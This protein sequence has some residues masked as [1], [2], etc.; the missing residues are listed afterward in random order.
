VNIKS[1]SSWIQKDSNVYVKTIVLSGAVEGSD[2]VVV[3]R[4]CPRF[5]LLQKKMAITVE[6]SQVSNGEELLFV[7]PKTAFINIGSSA[8]FTFTVDT[9]H[10][11]CNAS[12]YD[13]EM[14]IP[15]NVKLFS[16]TPWT[17]IDGRI[18]EKALTVTGITE[19]SGE[20]IVRRDCLDY[21]IVELVVPITVG[22]AFTPMQELP[23]FVWNS[24]KEMTLTE[25]A[26]YYGVPQDMLLSSLGVEVLPDITG[27]E[28]KD[29]YGIDK[30]DLKSLLESLFYATHQGYED[31][32]SSK[33][34]IFDIQSIDIVFLL[35]LATS[36]ILFV[37]GKYKLRYVT[38]AFS[39]LY[40][41]F[42]LDACICHLGALTN[43]LLFDTIEL[44]WIILV[45]I[46]L[47]A[48]VLF[49]RVFCGGI[50]I[51]GGVQQYLYDIRKKLLPI[52]TKHALPRYLGYGKFLVLGIMVYYAIVAS[53]AVFCEYD[54]FFN[55]F[56]LTFS[57]DVFGLLT[58]LLV[59]V[60]LFVER[61]FCRF[62]CPLGVLLWLGEHISI[63]NVRVDKE[64]CNSCQLCN[65]ICPMNKD[66]VSGKGECIGCGKCLEKCRKNS[67][68][69]GR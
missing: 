27:H 18:Y 68:Y 32:S 34:I 24:L 40:F 55:I 8:T 38:M 28:L 21:G 69:Y 48:S 11:D 67:I 66:L 57:W 49:G 54:P 23:D 39:L 45:V 50:C 7:S 17:D 4:A 37:M 2:Y 9:S 58:I 30:M 19:G 20:L 22:T 31:R 35:I 61:A 41:G 5:G 52:K 53:R 46:P 56:Y 51:F 60:S 62:A 59:L 10:T 47:V 15:E 43:F 63:F 25:I 16:Q 13:T 36:T 1:Q 64:S 65:K 12:I 26:A 14:I 6:S 44:H 42:Y 33:N 29:E 3:E